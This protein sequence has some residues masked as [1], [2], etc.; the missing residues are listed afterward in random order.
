MIQLE[1]TIV[2]HARQQLAEL[3]GALLLPKSPDRDESI[4]SAFW[5]LSGITL[6]AN[7]ANSGMSVEAAKILHH[8]DSEAAQAMGTAQV[9]VEADASPSFSTEAIQPVKDKITKI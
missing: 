3:R 1:N 2:E 4:Q 8:I 5:M 6:L 9:P 7:L